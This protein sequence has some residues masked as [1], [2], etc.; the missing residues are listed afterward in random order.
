MAKPGQ[1]S[2]SAH[3]RC[4][5]SFLSKDKKDAASDDEVS[6][7]HTGTS[8]ALEEDGPLP[9]M[10]DLSQTT[11][12]Q[13]SPPSPTLPSVPSVALQVGRFALLSVLLARVLA[14]RGLNEIGK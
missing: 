6:A 13:P 11:L 12:S 1:D 8:K 5:L 9:P 14:T 2:G 10:P 3:V 7:A 4:K